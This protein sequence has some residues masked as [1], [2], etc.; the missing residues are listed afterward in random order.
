L[1][2]ILPF[3]ANLPF[4]AIYIAILR[5]FAIFCNLICHFL[6]F[7]LPFLANL[8]FFAIYFAI[9]GQ[10]AIFLQFILPFLAKYK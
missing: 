10:F 8:P 1:Q 9:F 4:F 6:Q 3:L 7:N 5:Q 2:F